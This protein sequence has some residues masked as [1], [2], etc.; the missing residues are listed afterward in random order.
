[1]A[2]MVGTVGCHLGPSRTTALSPP[3]A[4]GRVGYEAGPT[5]P[6][7]PAPMSP[8]TR[9][10]RTVVSQLG[11]YPS[12]QRCPSPHSPEPHPPLLSQL[13]WDLGNPDGWWSVGPSVSRERPA[14]LPAVVTTAHQGFTP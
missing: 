12:L 4:T 8:S 5:Q 13:R 14:W 7:V 6:F 9:A 2:S 11:Q 3:P 10:P 1:M